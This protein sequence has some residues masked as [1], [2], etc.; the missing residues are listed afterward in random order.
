MAQRK[1]YSRYFII[2][3]EDEK[4]YSL[5]H[6]KQPT[7]YVKLELRN[8]K[9]KVSYYVQNLK[10]EDAPYYM[11]LILSKKDTNKILKLGELNIDEYGRADVSYE[12][13]SSNLGNTGL[14]V[15][16]ISGA[17]VS[18]FLDK[19]IIPVLSGFLTTDIPKW[20][21]FELIDMLA[22]KDDDEDKEVNEKLVLNEE[23]S[24]GDDNKTESSKENNKKEVNNKFKEYEETIEKI[25]EET[26]E[27]KSSIEKDKTNREDTT[28]EE[29]TDIVE[30]EISN[31][32]K[33][34]EKEIEEKNII[35]EDIIEHNDQSREDDDLD[36]YVFKC[37]NI[38]REDDLPRHCHCKE[39][40]YE[41]G[42]M[43]KFFDDIIDDLEDIS[44]DIKDIK[45]VKWYKVPVLN[46][47]EMY[48]INNYNK[49][50][51]L[52]YPMTYY[53]DYISKANHFVVGYKY[54]KNNKM[55]YIIYGIPGSKELKDQPFQGKTGFVTWVPNYNTN[56]EDIDGYWLMFYDFRRSTILIP[57]K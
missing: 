48:Y 50:T 54:N 7:G 1:S 38:K 55:K 18:K 22:E 23:E 31:S 42:E 32:N 20:R 21:E 44:D 45:R 40:E 41:K 19:N 6:D 36:I 30:K 17:A 43:E 4:G 11:I 2:L 24:T 47:E 16:D 10:K 28:S 25:K 46:K 49:Y 52:Y 12:Y 13:L 35:K 51:V 5:T 33:E 56:N 14:S 34:L 15:D 27:A 8:D 53:Y 39:K 37:E 3:Q 26:K 9:C 57:V 29:I